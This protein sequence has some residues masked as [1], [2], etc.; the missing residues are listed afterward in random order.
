MAVL[1]PLSVV[2]D[3]VTNSAI[4]GS[5]LGVYLIRVPSALAALDLKVS[6]EG[7]ASDFA[8]VRCSCGRKG[9]SAAGIFSSKLFSV[10]RIAALTSVERSDTTRISGPVI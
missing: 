3:P 2:F 10:R 5:I 9:F 8:N 7:S 1:T 4:R 6:L